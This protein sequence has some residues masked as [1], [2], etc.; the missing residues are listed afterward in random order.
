[1]ENEN[2]F[3]FLAKRATTQY[4]ALFSMISQ[5]GST[6][7]DIIEQKGD[8]LCCGELRNSNGFPI[9]TYTA[10]GMGLSPFV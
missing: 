3:L 2:P 6:I 9:F 8:V 1:M 10:G 5:V 7:K 4:S